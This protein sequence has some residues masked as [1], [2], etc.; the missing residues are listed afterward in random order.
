MLG[1]R[2][3]LCHG[4]HSVTVDVAQVVMSWRPAG[5]V[6]P[7]WALGG[8]SPPSLHA[9]I[10]TAWG[11][12]PL[13]RPPARWTRGWRACVGQLGQH[14]QYRQLSPWEKARPAGLPAPAGR[15]VPRLMSEP[16]VA[17]G[18]GKGHAETSPSACLGV[19]FGEP[20]SMCPEGASGVQ[21]ARHCVRLGRVCQVQL[22]LHP[23]MGS[24]GW[25]HRAGQAAPSWVLVGPRGSRGSYCPSCCGS[26]GK[27]EETVRGGPVAQTA[28][29]CHHVHP[30]A[31][32]VCVKTA[33]LDILALRPL[34]L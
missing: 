3:T 33:F 11:S 31:S 23:E 26:H 19:L 21:A 28:Q 16:S 18:D 15:G 17:C 29:S 13:L 22:M 14:G 1:T 8:A 20:S 12:S 27:A 7:D 30:R 5:P 4:L 25:G 9:G 32:W 2:G 34:P 6:S 10:P 24:P